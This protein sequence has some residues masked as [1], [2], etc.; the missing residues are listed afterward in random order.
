MT[1]FFEEWKSYE[2][3]VVRAAAP[4]VQREE[5]RRAFLAGAAI[6]Y[7][8]TLDATLPEDEAKCEA[9]LLALE[10]EIHA[11]PKDLRMPDGTR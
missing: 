8:L 10:A 7:K 6:G 11:F 1:T 9:N 3:D 4:P 5:C 2:R